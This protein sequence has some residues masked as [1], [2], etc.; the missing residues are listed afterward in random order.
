MSTRSSPAARVAEPRFVTGGI[1]YAAAMS[2]RPRYHAN[3]SSRDVLVLD[4]RTVAIEDARCRSVPPALAREGLALV[5]HRSAVAD[6]RDAREVAAA[7][8]REIERL[9]LEL[10]GADAV[11]VNGS[12]V[13]RFGERSADSGR[14]DN[15][16]PARFVHVDCSDATAAAFAE[17]SRPRTPER[18]LRRFAHYNVWRVFSP[19]PQDVPLAVCDA[20]S[21]APRDLVPADAVFDVTGQP[22]W[23]FEG[24]V[25][26]YNPDHRWLF[27]SE[28]TRDEVI[29]FKTHDSARGE[30]SQVPHSAFN[31]PTCPPDVPPRSSIEMR[32]CAYWFA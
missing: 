27:F 26:R 29:V 32:A 17:R 3:D 2:Q 11:V 22:E 20:R 7:H 1:N 16:R 28:M 13:L 6:F 9:V 15:S 21:V 18:A 23:S 12:G 24:L 14:H 10:S 4:A 25:V 8:P 19:P 30:P 5:A 31:D